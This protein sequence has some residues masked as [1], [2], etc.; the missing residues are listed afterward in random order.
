MTG[1][2]F[3]ERGDQDGVL[4]T[5]P[6]RSAP[7]SRRGRDCEMP[8]RHVPGRWASTPQELGEPLFIDHPVSGIFHYS[9]QNRLECSFFHSS[10]RGRG[11]GRKVVGGPSAALYGRDG[12][13]LP[14]SWLGPGTAPLPVRAGWD[15]WARPSLPCHSPTDPRLKALSEGS[16]VRQMADLGLSP[17][18]GISGQCSPGE[19]APLRA[20]MSPSVISGSHTGPP[21]WC[22]HLG[23]SLRAQTAPADASSCTGLVPLC[24]NYLLIERLP[25]PRP[26]MVPV[27][28]PWYQSVAC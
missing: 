11:Q 12:G 15:S 6:L 23:S 25:A 24:R 7:A 26:T 27:P 28:H 20:T 19:A 2:D 8:T 9:Q 14:E 13:R 10:A 5:Q 21:S 3:Q 16:T 18:S 4:W 1:S 22:Q 17:G